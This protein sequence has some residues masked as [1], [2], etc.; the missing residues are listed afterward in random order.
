MDQNPK[1]TI[2][3]LEIIQKSV[4]NH[5]KNCNAKSVK[6]CVSRIKSKQNM[7]CVVHSV[8]SVVFGGGVEYY[9]GGGG[10]IQVTSAAKAFF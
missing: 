3:S 2:K 9:G 8:D 10:G 4:E 1:M 7:H 5:S 6:K